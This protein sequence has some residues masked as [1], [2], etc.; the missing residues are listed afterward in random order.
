MLSVLER[1][2]QKKIGGKCK[3]RK[4][5]FLMEVYIVKLSS[6]KYSWSHIKILHFHALLAKN[7]ESQLPKRMGI[8]QL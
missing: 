6:F 3:N 4:N 1:E 2:I 5:D 8:F 7:S